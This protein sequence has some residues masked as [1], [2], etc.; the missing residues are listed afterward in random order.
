M[1]LLLM[2]MIVQFE[3]FLQLI[4]IY[5]L[6]PAVQDVLAPPPTCLINLVIDNSLYEV[7]ANTNSPPPQQQV[8]CSK[9]LIDRLVEYE[10]ASG[11]CGYESLGSIPL[12]YAAMKSHHSSFMGK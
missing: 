8:P 2:M 5:T 9:H 12:F 4:Y 7:S 1:L 10:P 3:D 6:T 11:Q